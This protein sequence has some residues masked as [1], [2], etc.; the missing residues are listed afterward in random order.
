[1]EEFIVSARKY[2]PSTFASVVGQDTIATTLKNAVIQNQVAQ[3]FLFCGPRGVGK[4]TCARILAKT[5][6]CTH[7]TPEGEACNECESCRSFNE[8]ASFNI[9]ELDAASNNSVD[10]I[11]SLVE[12]VRIP[13]QGAKYKVYI[14][15]EV[16]MLSQAA[17]NAFLKTLEEPPAY[18]KF[19]LATTEKH[20]ILPT[21]LSRCQVFD[22]KR[23][24]TED[25]TR[26]LMYVAKQEGVAYEEE[27]LRVIARKADGGLRDALSIFDQ[28]VIFTSGNITYK[29]VIENLNVLDLEY[30]LRMTR[31][32]YDGDVPQALL[33]FD[34]ILEKGFD[35]QHFLDGMCEHLRNLMVCRTPETIRLLEAS[36][37][38]R[39][40]YAT[41][42]KQ[43]DAGF[44]LSCLD[45]FSKCG[46]TYKNANNRRL[47]VELALMLCCRLREKAAPAPANAGTPQ[48]AANNPAPAAP[49]RQAGPSAV[50]PK[51]STA[52]AAATA[53]PVTQTARPAA[54]TVSDTGRA[55]IHSLMKEALQQPAGKQ[56]KQ[57]ETGE[58][59]IAMPSVPKMDAEAAAYRIKNDWE[60]LVRSRFGDKPATTALLL[61]SDNM[62]IKGDAVTFTVANKLEEEIINDTLTELKT[63]LYALTGNS[64]SFNF[65]LEE[66]KRSA[67]IINPDEKYRILSEKNPEL[68]NLKNIM[69][70]AVS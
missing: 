12:Q 4:T 64:Y 18:A 9:F 69:G 59:E 34:E 14:I 10:D 19:I 46:A 26:H 13:P 28:S 54:Y 49:S 39:S 6:N 42:V 33:T 57:P 65:R 2:R 25:I 45:L 40:Q 29:K 48:N 32:L 7:R 8:S 50:M 30:Y 66:K 5:I 16:H 44:L 35:G 3:A 41:Q 60:E 67:P 36:E 23:I 20:K 22:F 51:T 53:Q 56:E 38:V 52:P 61:R 21:I 17:F 37:S 62:L 27:A 47:Q 43:V 70:F 15:D 63:A 31:H 24:Q 68:N 1:M 55:S 11:R 58:A